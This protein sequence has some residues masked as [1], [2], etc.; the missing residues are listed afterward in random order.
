[1]TAGRPTWPVGNG[2]GDEGKAFIP[3]GRP[4]IKPPPESPPPT[5]CPQT[6]SM[7][8]RIGE[9]LAGLIVLEKRKEGV[10]VQ[11]ATNSLTQ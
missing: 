9:I 6:D 8:A 11:R 5:S 7:H 2:K 3:F 4:E 10:V 1:M